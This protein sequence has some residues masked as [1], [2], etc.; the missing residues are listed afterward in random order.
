LPE[1][2]LGLVAVTITFAP[3]L[4]TLHAVWLFFTASHMAHFAGNAAVL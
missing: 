1:L 4:G 2:F 3:R